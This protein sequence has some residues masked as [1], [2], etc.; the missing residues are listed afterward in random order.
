MTEIICMNCNT[1][2]PKEAVYC[3]ECGVDVKQYV[4]DNAKDLLFK[5]P[6]QDKTVLNEKPKVSTGSIILIIG[7][8]LLFLPLGLIVAVL[9]WYNNKKNVEE[10]QRDRIITNLET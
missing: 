5:K 2:I 4:K 9:V 3:P 8:C 6:E 1:P 10:W 7:L